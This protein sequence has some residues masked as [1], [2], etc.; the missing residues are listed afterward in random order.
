M[1]FTLTDW[2]RINTHT[3]KHTLTHTQQ[4]NTARDTELK[5]FLFLLIN[6]IFLLFFFSTPTKQNINKNPI[7]L[8]K[9]NKLNQQWLK[10]STEESERKKTTYKSNNDFSIHYLHTESYTQT[11][12]HT[13][14]LKRKYGQ[15]H[16]VYS[17]H[18][19]FSCV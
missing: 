19:S 14:K 2:R 13:N 4:T 9:K 15:V 12:T 18:T 5:L 3:S 8:H 16:S 17:I 6:I 11:H 1:K 7:G 10:K